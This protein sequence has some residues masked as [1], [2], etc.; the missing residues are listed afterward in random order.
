LKKSA[1]MGVL[2][3]S[4]TSTLAAGTYYA[5]VNAVSGSSIDY[6]LDFTKNNLGMLA[7]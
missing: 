7:S 6:K 4:I 5:R 2:E 3:D 1:S